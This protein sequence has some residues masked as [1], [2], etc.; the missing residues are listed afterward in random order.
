MAWILPKGSTIYEEVLTFPGIRYDPIKTTTRDRKIDDDSYDFAST[1]V[2]VYNHRTGWVESDKRRSD[3]IECTGGYCKIDDLVNESAMPAKPAKSSK[4]SKATTK[5]KTPAAPKERKTLFRTVFVKGSEW[6]FK[7]DCT[8]SIYREYESDY[9]RAIWTKTGSYLKDIKEIISANISEG[10]SI[11]PLGKSETYYPGSWELAKDPSG[12]YDPFTAIVVEIGNFKPGKEMRDGHERTFRF[13]VNIKEIE[14]LVEQ[15]NDF[16]P[17]AYIVEIDDEMY[18]ENIYGYVGSEA[19]AEFIHMNPS[20]ASSANSWTTNLG[21][22]CTSHYGKAKKYKTLQ[23]AKAGIM[24]MTGYTEGAD[25]I[26]YWTEGGGFTDW[27]KKWRI[28]TWDKTTKTKVDDVD[29][30]EWVYDLF[31]Y[32]DLVQEYGAGTREIIKRLQAGEK[33]EAVMVLER[34]DEGA[35]VY[36]ELLPS[37][38]AEVS[39]LLKETILDKSQYLLRRKDSSVT[40]GF[41]SIGDA[42]MFKLAYTGTLGI[43]MFDLEKMMKVI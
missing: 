10:V 27:K 2:P 5:P 23:A 13:L 32:R 35:P 6:K 16:T 19:K 29:V 4:P 25:G 33:F 26:D 15:T 40:I 8:I 18:Q 24:Y 30:T 22:G 42:M 37:E 1:M 31:K 28:S 14:D 38:Q 17:K 36:D 21:I 34:W 43:R 12:K 39:D 3:Y 41:K 11:K 9:S 20:K 7:S